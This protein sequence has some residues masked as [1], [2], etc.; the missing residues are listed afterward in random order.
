MLPLR[1]SADHRGTAARPAVAALLLAL[2]VSGCS[3]FEGTGDLEYIEGRGG[4]TEIP[5]ADRD[6]PVEIA[7]E[8]VDGDTLDFAD[9]RGK[10]VV[11]NVWGSW[12][13]PCR[14]E[15]PILVDAA[16]AADGAEVSFAGID[17][18]DTSVENARAF[19]RSHDVPYPSV[20]DRGGETLLRFGKRSP[21]RPPSTML[22]DR[23]GRVAVLISGSIPSLHTLTELIDD[24]VAEDADG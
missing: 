19:E 6:E 7:G 10:V 24:L 23:E 8:T 22:L 16:T 3:K 2:V 15:M 21:D 12:C 9:L 18:R 20:Y 14:A 11:V 1:R 4:I 13:T 5:A 17:I